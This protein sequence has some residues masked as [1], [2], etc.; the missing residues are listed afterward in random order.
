MVPVFGC[1][2]QVPWLQTP[3]L[4]WSEYDDDEQSIGLPAQIPCDE[5]WSF[6][7][8]GFPS[9]HEPV[10]YGCVQVPEEQM[11]SVHWL[12]SAVHWPSLFLVLPVPVTSIHL[13]LLASATHTPLEQ[14]F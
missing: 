1:F 6:M 13:T 14:R 9:S 12:E 8:Q 5:H 4:H 2:M 11:S 3:V 7:V 10:L